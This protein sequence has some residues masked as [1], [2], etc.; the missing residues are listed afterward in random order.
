MPRDR[1]YFNQKNKDKEKVFFKICVLGDGGVGKTSLINRYISGS[2]RDSYKMTIG[3]DFMSKVL[4]IKGIEVYLQIWDFAGEDRFRFLIPSY[5]DGASGGIFMYDITRL[6]SLIN[7]EE[8]YSILIK[9]WKEDSL[10][11]IVLIGGKSD[12]KR[13]RSV[14]MKQG[15]KFCQNHNMIKFIEC[16][17]KTG[18]NI[19]KIFE[20]LAHEMVDRLLKRN[21]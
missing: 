13:K 19:L 21:K 18:E 12:L 2:F 20:I 7:L 16:S 11:P 1:I 5:I 3:V 6:K 17:S 4:N 9:A 8:W 10:F 14:N 15:E